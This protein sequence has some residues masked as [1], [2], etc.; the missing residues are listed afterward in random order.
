M[1]KRTVVI[2]QNAIPMSRIIIR[3]LPRD[4]VGSMPNWF[5]SIASRIINKPAVP[6]VYMIT[7]RNFFI[8]DIVAKNLIL[9]RMV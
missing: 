1:P 5:A 6:D 7:K 9:D 8:R 2:T 3:P 4:G